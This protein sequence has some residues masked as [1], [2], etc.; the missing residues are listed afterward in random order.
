MLAAFVFACL[1]YFASDGVRRLLSGRGMFPAQRPEGAEFLVLGMAARENG[2]P[3]AKADFDRAWV[4]LA[5]QCKMGSIWL[6][7]TSNN[8]GLT[9]W[10][11]KPTYGLNRVGAEG[12]PIRIQKIERRP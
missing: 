1:V 11:L 3:K 8:R 5:T 7:A 4:Y 6:L 2:N 10:Y 12:S 9:A